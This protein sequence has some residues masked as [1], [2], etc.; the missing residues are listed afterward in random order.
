[1]VLAALWVGPPAS[2]EARITPATVDFGTQPQGRQS[3]PMAV[4]LTNTGRNSFRVYRT[5]IN[6]GPDNADFAV[7]KD[8][9]SGLDLAPQARC[10]VEIA[11]T[12][13]AAGSTSQTLGI[14]VSGPD[15]VTFGE[16]AAVVNLVGVGTVEGAVASTIPPVPGGQQD[17]GLGPIPIGLLILVAGVASIGLGFM[18]LATVR[19]PDA[20]PG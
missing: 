5:E 1:M 13:K 4:E 11:F 18:A 7:I 2:A 15:Y 16:R 3:A 6:T 17:G 8:G 19:P 12:P 9:C 10:A 20:R 14:D